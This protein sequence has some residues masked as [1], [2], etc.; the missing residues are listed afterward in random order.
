MVLTSR[1]RLFE[2]W[3]TLSTG[4]INR[5]LVGISVN[6]TNQTIH[7]IAIYPEDSVIQ[8]INPSQACVI[9][10]SFARYFSWK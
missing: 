8:S 5:Y 7:C 2:D 6:K 4:V 1:S 10:R 3:L 9:E